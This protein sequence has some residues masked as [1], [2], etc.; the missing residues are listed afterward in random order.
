MP[1]AIVTKQEVLDRLLRVFREDGYDGASL[2]EIAAATGL[3]KS[4]LYHHFPGGKVEMALEVLAH[5]EA[6]LEQALFAPLRSDQ[7]PRKKLTQMLD[8]VAAFYG[9]GRQACLLERLCASVD[10][11][12]F[13]RP[14][15]KVFDKWIEAVEV[16]ARD[17]GVSKSQ[18]RA[19]AEDF[20]VRVEGA[21]VV[22]AGTGD[23]SIFTRTITDLRISLFA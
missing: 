5:L 22:S 15:A 10:R 2:A 13:R 19:R 14:L 16:L 23:A 7:S 6:G 17:A 3:G 21:L 20:V 4:S 1:A 8:T 12:H 18:A 9:N 11:K